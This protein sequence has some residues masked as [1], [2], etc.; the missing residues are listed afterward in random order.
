MFSSRGF[1]NAVA[2][3]STHPPA[4]SSR[5]FV[6]SLRK[7]SSSS[8]SPSPAHA[9]L[10]AFDE[11][12]F[13]RALKAATWGTQDSSSPADEKRRHGPTYRDLGY[14]ATTKRAAAKDK[15]VQLDEERV[16]LDWERRK[17]KSQVARS[18]AEAAAAAAEAAKVLAS[19]GRRGYATMASARTAEGDDDAEVLIESDAFVR[20]EWLKEAGT[21]A[22]VRYGDL[23][24][25][26]QD[27]STS[28]VLGIV[29]AV[30]GPRLFIFTVNSNLHSIS[31]EAI[32]FVIPKFT[33]AGRCSRLFSS[34][35]PEI[36]ADAGPIDTTVKAPLIIT[37]D[38]IALTQE[39]RTLY[40]QIDEETRNLVNRGIQDIHRI[41]TTTRKDTTIVDSADVLAILGCSITAKDSTRRRQVRHYA[42]HR[43]LLNDSEHFVADQQSLRTS[44]EFG[45]RSLAE[46]ANIERVRTWF[47]NRTPEMEGFVALAAEAKAWGL[48]N[49]PKYD[50]ERVDPLRTY[51]GPDWTRWTATDR[52]IIAFLEQ[53]L[54]T[55]R[56]QID[57]YAATSPSIV[58]LVDA[59]LFPPPPDAPSTP[60]SSLGVPSSSSRPGDVDTPGLVR[61][62]AEIGVAAPWENWAVKEAAAELEPWE[63]EAESAAS[64]PSLSTARQAIRDQHDSVRKD[65]GSL[66]VY[67]IDDAGAQELDDGISLE[68][69]PSTAAGRPTWWVHVHVA[70]PTSVISPGDGIAALAR[71]RIQTEYLP[72]RTYPMISLPFL[73]AS[74][75]SLGSLDGA[76]Q[77]VLSFSTRVDEEGNVLEFDIEAAI[78]RKVRRLT[79]N[80]VD[81]LLGYTPLPKR[82]IFS[83]VGLAPD[84]RPR[85]KAVP[86]ETDDALLSTDPSAKEDLFT[87]SRLAKAVGRHRLA[88]AVFWTTP[89]ADVSVH[90]GV[91]HHFRIPEHPT[92]YADSPLVSMTLP[93]LDDQS[94]ASTLLVSELMVLANRNAAVFC[95]DRGIHVPYSSQAA[96]SMTEDQSAIL[97]ASRD[98]ETGRVDSSV[99]AQLGLQVASSTVS[100]APGPQWLMGINDAYVKATSPLRR[101][102]DLVFHWQ[103]K[104]T[105]LPAGSA[106]STPPF[107][108]D[109]VDSEI[110]LGLVIGKSRGRLAMHST[111][112]W[113]NYVLQRKLETMRTNPELDPFAM[114]ILDN[115]TCMAVRPVSFNSK[116]STWV[117]RVYLP[118]L[119]VPARLTVKEKDDGLPLGGFGDVRLMSVQLSSRSLL[120]VE[121]KERR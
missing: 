32:T 113:A 92:F 53:G 38:A 1:T 34:I 96:P 110:T 68:A 7:K 23:V 2:S 6:R 120:N 41:I 45:V 83:E 49:P 39:L 86:R 107:T 8:S 100:T 103:V 75:L 65:F 85:S 13:H 84:F 111:N 46:V 105:L 48:R 117:Q 54:A 60:S 31:R 76:G 102:L 25:V 62:L 33:S 21:S 71:M 119:G 80:A 73:Q 5:V 47:R 40:S 59:A 24:E 28:S 52:T 79:Y 58:K 91:D 61:F 19:G 64:V 4:T 89:R 12:V 87:L 30:A 67:V 29:L 43:T 77:N 35:A 44:G 27:S 82:T 97:H 112:Y 66:P 121:L 42:A 26:R 57:P 88:N 16:R 78:V 36:K 72:E 55:R 9:P 69:G 101:Y 70:D 118:T 17:K 20:E 51:G 95:R 108:R 10:T 63:A 56:F 114:E 11:R 3:C 18:K 106:G 93:T 74:G 99:M 104:A 94:R 14:K 50:S 37:P 109:E 22:E 116:T 81:G 15:V 90:P 115:L 98:V